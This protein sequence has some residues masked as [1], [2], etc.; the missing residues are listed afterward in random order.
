MGKYIRIARFDHW[1][2]NTFILPG[3]LFS[4]VMAKTSV[5]KKIIVELIFCISGCILISSANYTINEW[6]DREFDRRHPIKKFRTAVISQLDWKFVY[7]QYSVLA[8]VGLVILYFQNMKVFI[9][10]LLLLFMGIIY[11]VRPFRLKDKA[12]VDVLTES[13]NNPIRLSVG[14]YAIETFD[15][16]PASL[17]LSAYGF[18]IFLMTLKR[19]A[20]LKILKESAANYRISFKNWNEIKLLT[21]ALL[22][23]LIGSIFLGIFMVLWRIELILTVPFLILLIIQYFRMSLAAS[24]I[25]IS[26]E[27]LYR[28]PVLI[29]LVSL[30]ALS[31]VLMSITEIPYLRDMLV[32]R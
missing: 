32:F 24:E 31:L 13:V 10:G 5:D 28:S 21:V 11:N 6:L 29:S 20:E 1:I 9:L 8:T 26:P 16:V 15:V 3:A 23:V 7:I 4:I 30:F 27:K 18:G 25:A 22:G 2:K 19:F 12:V 17:I 14:W